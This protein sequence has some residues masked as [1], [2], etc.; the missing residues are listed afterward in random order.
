MNQEGMI[1]NINMDMEKF[2]SD[3]SK[4]FE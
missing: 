3:F 1:I 2:M 4:R